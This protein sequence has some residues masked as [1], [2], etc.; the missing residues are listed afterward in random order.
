[1]E[2]KRI[3]IGVTECACGTRHAFRFKGSSTHIEYECIKC[4]MTRPRKVLW[5]EEADVLRDILILLGD[6]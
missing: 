6:E 4:R 3:F 2:D 5:R 1:M